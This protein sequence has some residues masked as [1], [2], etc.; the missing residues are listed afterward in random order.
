[1]PQHSM[2][3]WPLHQR[4]RLHW[5]N[6]PVHIASMCTPTP[7]TQWQADT[8]PCTNSYTKCAGRPKLLASTTICISLR[9]RLCK[10]WGLSTGNISA[11]SFLHK[12]FFCVNFML[13]TDHVAQHVT[14]ATGRVM[15]ICSRDLFVQY[16][17][18]LP[19]SFMIFFGHLCMLQV[20][21]ACLQQLPIPCSSHSWGMRAA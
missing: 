18:G 4:T 10:Q 8:L 5:W 2:M 17:I 20:L 12:K 1:M 6:R 16:Q 3:C 15:T 14:L 9:K 11:A 7:W 21:T 13:C 19:R